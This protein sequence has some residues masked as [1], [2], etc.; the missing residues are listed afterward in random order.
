MFCP[1]IYDIIVPSMY[2]VVVG[3]CRS[4]CGVDDGFACLAGDDT[5]DTSGSLSEEKREQTA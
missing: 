5:V 2:G 1:N 4:V 3:G